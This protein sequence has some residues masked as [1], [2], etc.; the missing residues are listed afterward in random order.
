MKILEIDPWLKP[1]A[2]DLELRMNRYQEL[3]KVLLK[4]KGKLYDFANGHHYFGFHRQKDG[5]IY[6]EW[7]P[8]ADALYLM[9][10][11]NHWDRY[12]HPLKKRENG[13]WEIY[14]PDKHILQH[15][16][17]VK[18]HVVK[19]GQGKDRIPLYIRSVV[20]DKETHDFSGQIWKPEKPFQWT[21]QDFKVNP[22]QPPFIYEVHIGMA[23]EKEGIGTYREF[24]EL[25]L[26]RIKEQGYN[27]I[28]MMAI[29]QHPY[30]AS[31]G[32]HVSNYFAASSWFGNPEELKSLINKAHEMGITVLMDMVQ[33]HAVKNVAEG[34][35]GFDG[36]VQQFFHDGNRG[37]HSAWDSK[38]FNYGKH[39]VIHFLL[40]SL[41]YWMEEF[42]FDGFRFDGVTSMIYHDH[43]LG[44]AFDHYKKYFSLNTDVEALNYLQLANELIKEVRPDAVSIAED[45][46]GMPG[47]CLPI[48]YGGIGFDY[49]LSMG[50]PD[51]WIKTLEKNDED[52]DMNAMY[53]ELSTSRP[54][55]KRVGYVESHDQALVGDKTFIFRLADKEM[56]NSMEK[57]SR[58]IVIDR[59]IALH[60]MARL[61][62]ISLGSEGYLTFMGNE[63]GH[64]EWIDFPREGNQWSFKYCR[65]QWSLAES[66]FLR[67]KDLNTFDK[68]MVSLMKEEDLMGETAL[69]CL[70]I[71]NEK[72]IIGYQK[73]GYLFLYNFH[74]EKSFE[75][76][77]IPT[78]QDRKYQVILSTDEKRFDGDGHIDHQV[79]YETVDLKNHPKDRGILVY[80]PSRT[81][82]VLKAF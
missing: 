24:E 63:F 72:K 50:M 61:I 38:L 5:W 64:P 82:M 66:P 2:N 18:V 58:S 52:W 33:S 19:E 73:K 28:Q 41:K 10:D 11:F 12:Q 53:H 44:T 31:F 4:E 54:S 49:R 68:A 80:L 3:K 74:P 43:G 29:M 17:R 21:D 51:F 67:Y 30:Y 69:K 1:Y 62:T 55:E 16:S 70:T 8:A 76:L 35:N 81:A 42:H 7:A 9:G 22:G 32:Y 47:M 25:V 45:M 14:L 78:Y 75:G 59:A 60:K 79:V 27:T 56:Y 48:H 65:R 36:T 46:S 20:Q 6:R 23:Q 26:P 34:I 13:I 15:G 40:S 39:E 37:T 57:G 71:D 77:E